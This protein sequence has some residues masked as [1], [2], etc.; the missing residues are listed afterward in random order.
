LLLPGPAA[1]YPNPIFTQ[2]L[3][4]V[5]AL[6]SIGP[7][8]DLGLLEPR[9]AGP[10]SPGRLRVPAAWSGRCLLGNA[11]RGAAWIVRQGCPGRA[12]T[13]PDHSGPGVW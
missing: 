9:R 13:D 3:C 5:N 6:P 8:S 11:P 4:F 1:A 12:G 7:V 10:V 2:Y